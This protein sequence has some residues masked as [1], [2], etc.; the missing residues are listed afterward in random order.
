[1]A[2]T[3]IN[4]NDTTEDRLKELCEKMEL[5]TSAVIRI[6]IRFLYE[7]EVNNNGKETSRCWYYFCDSEWL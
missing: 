6:A 5:N 7:Q 4:I 2:R 3:T 1:M